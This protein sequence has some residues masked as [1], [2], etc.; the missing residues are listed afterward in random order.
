MIQVESLF[1]I[2]YGL[3]VV[4]SGS[5]ARGNGYVS[6]TVFQVT[7]N[8][9]KIAT[10]CSKNN[11]TCD[12]IIQS[13]AFSV[14]VLH[15]NTSQEMLSTLGYHSG[16]DQEK[17][18][19]YNI[20]YGITG[21]PMMREQ[22]ISVIECKVVQKL[23][24]GTHIL[25]IGEVIQTINVDKNQ[26]PMTYMYFRE[27]RK[28]LSPK[29]APTFVEKSNTEATQNVDDKNYKCTVCGYVYE[30]KNE[31]ISFTDLPHEWACPICGVSKEDFIEV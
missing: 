27:E 3:Y 24:V 5:Q 6:N 8:P 28:G 19:G 2:S 13:N 16:K 31:N 14:S 17:L 15:Q 30:N 29:N 7:A 25:F 4:T 12:L 1:D 18:S 10:C 11:F 21:V 26:Q 9:L 22:C 20:E 23:D